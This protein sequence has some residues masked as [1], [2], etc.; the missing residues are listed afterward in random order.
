MSRM[1]C[2]SSSISTRPTRFRNTSSF[3]ST[4]TTSA[5]ISSWTAGTSSCLPMPTVYGGRD[6]PRALARRQ[7]RSFGRLGTGSGPAS[8]KGCSRRSTSVLSLL[9]R[10]ENQS[11]NKTGVLREMQPPSSGSNPVNGFELRVVRFGKRPE[12]RRGVNVAELVWRVDLSDSSDATQMAERRCCQRNNTN[13][14]DSLC[15]NE[16]QTRDLG[17]NLVSRRFHE[18][19]LSS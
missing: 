10:P 17:L 14:R 2:I 18:S 1:I 4:S 19:W 15:D 8:G 12:S 13:L 11:E 9:W 6:F 3:C 16:M 5:G 7:G